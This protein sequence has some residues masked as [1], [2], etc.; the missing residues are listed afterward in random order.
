MLFRTETSG[1]F[2]VCHS[3]ASSVF[4]SSRLDGNRRGRKKCFALTPN[5]QWQM[6]VFGLSAVRLSNQF[7]ISFLFW[8]SLRSYI[9]FVRARRSSQ[10]DIRWGWSAA[11]GSIRSSALCDF[12]CR[13]EFTQAAPT[14]HK[15]DVP[16][17]FRMNSTKGDAH[18]H[19]VGRKRD[20]IEEMQRKLCHCRC[21][22]PLSSAIFHPDDFMQS[23]RNALT[24]QPGNKLGKYLN[25]MICLW[26]TE[27]ASSLLVVHRRHRLHVTVSACEH[28]ASKENAILIQS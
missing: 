9:R 27:I 1:L 8:A 12:F 6:K 2:V 7:L 21:R 5:S 16:K 15:Q 17:P 14:R 26:N 19:I 10:C 23:I 22:W 20:L 18:R 4:A 25:K 13:F 24:Q 11:V 28:D 3:K